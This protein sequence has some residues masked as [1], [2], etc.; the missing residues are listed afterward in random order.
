M[1]KLSI[2]AEHVNISIQLTRD[3][4]DT[5]GPRL[6]GSQACK[7]SAKILHDELEKHCDTVQ[8][9]R[10]NFHP[11]A[12]FG[13][14]E[15][16]PILYVLST[17]LLL[18][19]VFYAAWIGFV[20]L[21]FV[22]T[23]QFVFYKRFLD[24]LY[25]KSQGINVIGTIEPAAE[26]KQQVIISGHHDSARIFRL[27]SFNAQLYVITISGAVITG[28][29]AAGV[30]TYIVAVQILSGRIL[31]LAELLKYIIPCAAIFYIPLFCKNLA[32][33]IKP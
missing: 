14:L 27:L 20:L 7:Q 9:H 28:V 3:I 12:F 16:V 15:L 26:V 4:I 33:I 29:L 2:T 6:A 21:M 1:K 11:R 30:L 25:T 17:F 5:C 8:F 32:I 22:F 31:Y 24:P 19:N 13:H 10:F 18:F 23:I